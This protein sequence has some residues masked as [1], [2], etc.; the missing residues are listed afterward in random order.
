MITNQDK[1]SG[2]RF[3]VTGIYSIKIVGN[4]IIRHP[5]TF[6][7]YLD[8]LNGVR[9]FISDHK[10]FDGIQVFDLVNDVELTSK[11]ILTNG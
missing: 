2:K 7:V 10:P 8:T 3:K 5:I 4:Y 6:T 11:E 1:M 9:N